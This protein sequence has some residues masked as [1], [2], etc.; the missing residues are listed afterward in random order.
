MVATGNQGT[1]C[2]EKV[3]GICGA[4]GDIYDEG[5]PYGTEAVV[6]HVWKTGRWMT[7]EESICAVNP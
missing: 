6:L 1:V 4:E 3:F 5:V 2:L 7:P